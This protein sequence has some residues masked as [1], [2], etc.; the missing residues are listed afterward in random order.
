MNVSLGNSTP[1]PIEEIYKAYRL[2]YSSGAQ[3]DI[4][5][6]KIETKIGNVPDLEKMINFI[7]PIMAEGHV[8]PLEH[9]SFTFYIEGISRACS[10]QLV[11]HR[12]GKYSQQS[13]R[14]VNA[15]NFEFVTPITIQENQ[16]AL[17]VYRRVL[18]TCQIGY[19]KL[20]EL[21]IPK[22]DAR[23]LLPNATTTN[24]TFTIDLHNFRHFLALRTCV[25]AQ[26]EIRNLAYK[27]L[28]L[29]KKEVP[30]VDYKYKNCGIIC[31]KCKEV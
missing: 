17:D 21:G 16:Q 18:N 27:M 24:V 20:I 10:H 1:N 6:P 31:H 14:Y 29:V 4:I 30:F 15:N 25:R 3:E 2:C 28:Y 8:S 26:A 23:F 22:E 19:N 7:K 9:V 12:T 5:I 11:R 13:Q